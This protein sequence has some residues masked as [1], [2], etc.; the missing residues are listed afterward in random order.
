MIRFPK[1]PNS[2]FLGFGAGFLA[3]DLLASDESFTR[4]LVK[5]VLKAGHSLLLKGRESFAHFTETLEDLLAEVQAEAREAAVR[6]AEAGMATT[7]STPASAPATTP[8]ESVTV[9]KA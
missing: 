7:A 3:R 6:K 5:G 8:S 9:Q 4:P 1:L 2:F